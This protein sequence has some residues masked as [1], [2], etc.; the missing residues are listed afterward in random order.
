[1]ALNLSSCEDVKIA[2]E[3]IKKDVYR[4][5][6]TAV[7]EKFLVEKML[8]PPIAELLVNVRTDS[9]FGMVMTLAAGGIQ[10]EL[11]DDAVTILLPT[12][13]NDLEN[14]LKS[15]KISKLFDGFRGGEK[16]DMEQ[17]VIALLNLVEGVRNAANRI[18]EIEINPLFV[19][20]EKVCAVDVLMRVAYGTSSSDDN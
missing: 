20:K 9:Q 14:A 8:E 16:I 11:L 13:R 7:S 10:T 2:V 6:S 19:F 5:D 12:Y 18:K 17:L 1:M 4:Y 15:L 3:R